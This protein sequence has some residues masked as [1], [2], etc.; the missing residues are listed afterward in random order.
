MVD[1]RWIVPYNLHLAT[2]YHGHINME[3]CSSISVVKY[4]YKYVYKGH[5]RAIVVVEKWVDTPGQENNAQ[6]VVANGEWKNRDEIKAYLEGQYVFASKASW[7]LFSFRMHD[8]TPFVTRLTMHEPRIH[9]VVYNDNVSIFEIVNS[10]Q[11]QKTTLTEYFQANIDYPLAKEITYMDFPFMFTWTNGTKKWTIRQ[12]RCCVGRLYFVSPSAGEC[13]FLCTLLTKVKGVVS[14]EALRT[15]NG[16]IHDTFKLACI[17]LSLYD[18]IDEW[19]A[20]LEEVVNMQTCAELQFLFVTILAFGVPSEPRMLWDN[21]K[22][23]ICDDCKVALQR[24]GIV[25]SSIEKIESWALHSLRD[26]LAK[27]SKT[28]EDFG[29][30]APSVAFDWL[31]TNRLLEV[32]RDYNVEVLQAEVAMAIENLNDGQC[33][34]YNGVIDAYAAHHAKVIFIDGPAGTGKTYIENLILNF[35]R[36][37]GDIAFAVA[38][39]GIVALLLLG[40]RTTHSYLKIPI[41]LDR[42]SF[43]YIRKQDDLATLIRQTKLI[44]LDEAPMT[45]KL[46]FEVVDRTLRDLT[47]EN[48]PFGGIVFVMSMDFCQVLPVIPRGSYVDIISTS[49]KNSYLW[50]FVEL[51]RLSENMRVGDVVIV[52]PNLGNRTFANWL[53]CLGNNE[54]ETIDEDYI[55][56]P[57]MMVLPPVD[58]WAM[59]VAIYPRLHEGQTTNEY[60][61]EC[62]ILA[63]HNKEVSLINTMVL[64][65][66][67]GAQVDFLSADSAEDTEVANTY[68]SEFLNIL[69]INGM[70][71]HKLSFKIGAPVMLLHNLDPSIGLCNGTRLIVRRFTMRVIEAEIIIGKGAGNVAFIPRI[72]F[73]FDNSGLPFTFARKQFPLQLA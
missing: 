53:L 18:S 20:Y 64:N 42:M 15:I 43:C 38:S 27:F 60:L 50:E 1:N 47:D 5:D 23:H 28:L 58:T 52:Y 32:E 40:G 34:A 70:P 2:K 4:L 62:A 33:A 72:K 61:R 56:C 63:P 36:S 22:E 51:F 66:L 8:G 55:K 13:Y 10:E 14:F 17:A 24:R 29:H 41:V 9:T 73:I 30:H 35:V 39:L 68:P 25:E 67:L 45:N 11:N 21:Y 44:L 37:C 59:V 54:L 6:A 48:E 46:A 12:R 31:E 49:I 3:I 57:N 65:Y 7:R 69:E 26:A 71:S 19:N 16:V